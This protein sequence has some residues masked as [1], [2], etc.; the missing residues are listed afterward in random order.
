MANMQVAVELLGKDNASGAIDKVNDSLGGLGKAAAIGVGVA[1]AAVAGFGVAAVKAA[2]SFEKGMLE[3]ATLT[4][5]VANNLKSMSGDVLDLSARLGVDAVGSTKA[6]YQ[7]ISAGVPAD[8][9]ISF[10]ETASKAAVAGVTDTE[11]AVNGITSAVNAFKPAGLDAGRAADI[12]FATVKA[13]KTD[14]GQLSGA[15]SNVAPIAATMGVS[16]EE[17]SAAM[18]TLTLSGAQT[19]VASTQV[20]AALTALAKPSEALTDIFQSAGFASGEAAVKQ[21]G[22]A[23]ASDIV[24]EA[25]GGSIGELT[26]LLGSTEAVAAVLGVTGANAETFGGVLDGIT[27]SAGAADA[28]FDVMSQGFEQQWAVMQSTFDKMLITIGSE[29]LPIVTPLVTA[30]GAALP[31]AF[32]TVR[33]VLVPLV[34]TLSHVGGIISDL[35]TS[36]G[37]LGLLADNLNEAFGID[38]SPFLGA[39]DF[40]QG[41][42]RGV[43]DLVKSNVGPTLVGLGAIIAV[44]FG[45]A[46]IGAIGA[47]LTVLGTVVLP[48]AAIGLAAAALKV[49]WDQNLGGVQEKA[50]AVFGVL[51]PAFEQMAGVVRQVLAGDMAGAFSTFLGIVGTVASQLGPMLQ[52][53]AQAFLAWIGPMIPPLLAQLADL[54]GQALGWIAAQVPGIISQLG[55]WALAFVGWIGNAIPAMLG[56]F[57]DL[58]TGLLDGIGTGGDEA[59]N[60]IISTWIPAFVNWVAKAIPLVIGAV[61]TIGIALGETIGRIAASAEAAAARIGASIA[62]GIRS[63]LVNT[64]QSVVDRLRGLVDL[65]PAAVK[66]IL[67]I[68]SPSKAFEIIG[69]NI[70]DGLALGILQTIKKP[71]AATRTMGDEV[72]DA[73]R[74]YT[75]DVDRLISDTLSKFDQI[76]EKA[77]QSII[78]ATLSAGRAIEDVVRSTGQKLQDLADNLDLNRAIRGVRDTFSAGMNADDARFRAEMTAE[79]KAFRRQREDAEIAF[80]HDKDLAALQ[81]TLARNLA[82][83]KTDAERDE[84]RRRHKQAQDELDTR[85]AD[86]IADRDR[87]RALEEAEVIFRQGLAERERLHRQEQEAK[88]RAF[89]DR[90]EEEA[91]ARQITR[92]HAEAE[93]RMTSIHDT[94][95]EKQTSI[96]AQAE[97]ERMTLTQSLQDRLG[98]LKTAFVDKLPAVLGNA[99]SVLTSF[100]DRVAEQTS[101]STARMVTAAHTAAAAMQDIPSIQPRYQWAIPKF[102]TGGIVPGPIGAPRL[103]IAH[104]GETILP[105]H[106]SGASGGMQA[107]DYDRLG[108]AVAG[109][110]RAAPPVVNVSDVRGAL[111]QTSRYNGRQEAL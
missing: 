69:H 47:V 64:W 97:Q 21:L 18:A 51:R 106:K 9:A 26:K 94:L 38:I 35:I 60:K 79:E 27:N 6:L 70:T 59:E 74:S 82:G 93:A 91:L 61:L 99:E 111:N 90:L 1:S 78:D 40:A 76:G 98:D 102:D 62:D 25:A 103:V 95:A 75:R 33:G 65:L 68:A 12:M 2:S 48:L 13:G 4:P 39:L 77:G 8:N 89:D 92:I 66:Q 19:S 63:G 55:A 105:T 110:L 100:L 43:V 85:F 73:M 28:A 37:D 11:T 71:V 45:P 34:Q 108:A 42:M 32:E 44:V 30:F 31:S 10:L 52:T 83:A 14:F 22:F 58:V 29:L 88:R 7:A 49:A 46:V 81:A 84:I 50:Q 67:G 107:I 16:F 41:A 80:R 101:I 17:V 20:R 53:W 57:G 96:E 86:G 24:R 87:R 56:A 23:G 72:L 3:V 104:G 5:D 36:G 54:G 15:M 109:A